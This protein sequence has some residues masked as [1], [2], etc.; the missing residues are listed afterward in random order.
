MQLYTSDSMMGMPAMSNDMHPHLFPLPARSGKMVAVLGDLYTFLVS[1][2]ETNGAFAALEKIIRPENGPPPHIH[3]SNDET[4]YVMEGTF[5]FLVGDQTVKAETGAYVYVP[6]G[7]V[8]TFKNIGMNT[9][10]LLVT[11]T[12]SGFEKYFEAIGTPVSSREEAF[13]MKSEPDIELLV[14][15]APKYNLEFRLS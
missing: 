2:E 9:G 10:R 15:L 5:S 7:T 11:I 12:P 6:R 8:H 1:T 3:H 4:L 14:A 13:A